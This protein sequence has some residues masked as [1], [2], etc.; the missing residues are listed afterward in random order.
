M[1]IDIL[2]IENTCIGTCLWRL[3]HIFNDALDIMIG[4]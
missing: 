3:A 1:I 2:L 4:S